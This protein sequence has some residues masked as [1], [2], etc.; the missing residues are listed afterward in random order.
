MAHPFR[1]SFKSII[2]GE[3]L[4]M[5]VKNINMLITLMTNGQDWVPFAAQDLKVSS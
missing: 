5:L 1:I 3:E 2:A 4:N